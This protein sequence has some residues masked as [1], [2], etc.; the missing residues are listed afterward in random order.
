[1]PTSQDGENIKH[2]IQHKAGKASSSEAQS[3]TLIQ[4]EEYEAT[5]KADEGLSSLLLKEIKLCC[6]YPLL[7]PL[8]YAI[9]ISQLSSE[10]DKKHFLLLR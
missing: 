10:R 6:L 2:Q 3:P 7:M 4:R 9:H 5:F 1:M 8:T